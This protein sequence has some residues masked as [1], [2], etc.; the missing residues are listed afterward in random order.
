MPLKP[1]KK[2]LFTSLKKYSWIYSAGFL[3]ETEKTVLSWFLLWEGNLTSS[4]CRE[5]NCS[6]VDGLILLFAGRIKWNHRMIR[7]WWTS[8]GHLVEPP[9]QT[10]PPRTGCTGPC[11]DCFWIPPRWDSLDKLIWCWETLTVNSLFLMFIQKFMCFSLCTLPIL[12]SLGTPE[13]NIILS[14]LQHSL[15]YLYLLVRSPES[16]LLQAELVQLSQPFLLRG[17]LQSIHHWSLCSSSMFLLDWKAQNWTWYSRCNLTN[18]ENRGNTIFNLLVTLICSKNTLLAYVKINVHQDNYIL[19][20]I[21]LF[22][23]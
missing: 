10:G 21:P 17:M 6:C 1:R 12:P 3:L 19:I 13:K 9:A 15:R 8:G 16:S 4:S 23:R 14:S 2:H 7:V 18:A 5:R 22:P 20:Q 11:P